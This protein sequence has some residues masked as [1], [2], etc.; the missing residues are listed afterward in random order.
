MAIRTGDLLSRLTHDTSSAKEEASYTGEVRGGDGGIVVPKKEREIVVG[1]NQ[2]KLNSLG[3]V[4]GFH[5]SKR[6]TRSLLHSSPL[7]KL[8]AKSYNSTPTYK[9]Y[10]S[11][12]PLSD[13]KTYQEAYYRIKSNSGSMTP[14]IDKLTVDG[15]SNDR[16]NKIME[17]VKS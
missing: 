17:K 3:R 4:P 8:N 15:M 10:I 14:G 5:H 9:R 6:E 11:S 13:L 2:T 12:K 16:L 7:L 1:L